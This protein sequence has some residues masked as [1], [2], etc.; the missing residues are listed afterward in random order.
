MIG[1][2]PKTWILNNIIQGTKTPQG[3]LKNHNESKENTQYQ[4]LQDTVK[5]ITEKRKKSQIIKLSFHLK[6]LD[7][8]PK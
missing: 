2:F 6:K 3:K 7:K 1:K 8:R 4:K 5:A